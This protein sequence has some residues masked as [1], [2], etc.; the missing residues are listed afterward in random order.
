MTKVR[1]KFR[2][3]V[4][5]G[6]FIPHYHHVHN[7]SH[8]AFVGPL[9]G[10]RQSAHV[11]RKPTKEKEV[12]LE[13]IVYVGCVHGGS[14]EIY[15]R[16]KLLIKNPPDYLI[17]TGDITGSEKIERLKKHFYDEKERNKGS[18]FNKF[19]YFGDWAA[20]FPKEKRNELLSGLKQGAQRLLE[21]LTKIK[22]QGAKIFIIEGNWDNPQLSGVKAIARNDI[23]DIFDTEAFFKD[24]G[25]SFINQLTTIKTKTTLQIL[26]PYISLLQ[27]NELTKTK[28]AQVKRQ[29][30]EV[31]KQEKV[32]IMVGHAEANWRIHHLQQKEMSIAAGQRRKVINNFGRAMA[33]FKPDEVI[34]PHQHARIR[35]EKGKLIDIDTKYLLE[36]NHDGVR[37]VDSP[38]SVNSDNKQIIAI[39]VPLGYLA[40]EDFAG[41]S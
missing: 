22:K 3:W 18:Q 24:H 38:D 4:V 11:V 21:I 31:R 2:G 34:Y 9:I 37:L 35:D 10:L 40:E 13:R 12:Y 19:E 28:L 33:L 36:V 26:L 5:P 39:Y 30:E 1:K 25:I 27:F 20:T 32:I 14:E 41:V 15:Q 6:Q 8:S 16:L 23:P 17:F 29:I 7:K